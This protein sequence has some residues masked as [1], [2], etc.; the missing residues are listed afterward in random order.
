MKGTIVAA[1]TQPV[2]RIYQ[3][4]R[5]VD[6]IVDLA[7]AVAFSWCWNDMMW[8]RSMFSIVGDA[9][10]ATWVVPSGCE[11]TRGIL[12]VYEPLMNCAGPIMAGKF[13]N[14]ND[15]RSTQLPTYGI[16]YRRSGIESIE[17]SASD[18][19]SYYLD[20]WMVSHLLDFMS[21]QDGEEG[22]SYEWIIEVQGMEGT[23]DRYEDMKL[24]SG[25]ITVREEEDS[26]T[27]RI[28]GEEDQL[29]SILSQWNRIVITFVLD[30]S[31]GAKV[32]DLLG[33][34]PLLVLTRYSPSSG[35]VHS[36]PGIIRE[37][38]TKSNGFVYDRKHMVDEI[39]ANAVAYVPWL[40][41]DPFHPLLA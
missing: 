15:S 33:N 4:N 6:T 11:V 12:E 25:N 9:V 38:T 28:V 31:E 20:R 14:W 23:I 32:T 30:C 34:P 21:H 26:N 40:L 17:S 24:E 7:D 37:D 41:M 39:R 8:K 3:S 2:A 1:V 36:V 18:V 10:S 16:E 22:I 29:S 19:V 35:L 13:Q 5:S 27:R